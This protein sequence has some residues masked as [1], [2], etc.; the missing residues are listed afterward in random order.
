MGAP[1]LKGEVLL[2]TIIFEVYVSFLVCSL[3][4]GTVDG[5]EIRHSPVDLIIYRVWE[6]SQVVQDFFHQQYHT[7][8]KDLMHIFVVPPVVFWRFFFG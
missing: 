2:E 7:Q 6:T 4:V 1:I 3:G 8:K 5:S